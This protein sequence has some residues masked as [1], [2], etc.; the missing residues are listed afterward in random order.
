M[1]DKIKQTSLLL[2]GLILS[3]PLSV[4]ADTGPWYQ[5]EVLVF[6][7]IAPGAGSTESWKADPGTP[8]QVGAAYLSRGPALVNN[9]PV[10]YRTLP[11]EKRVLN[12]AWGVMRRSRDYRPLYHVAWRQQVKSP[13]QAKPIYFSLKPK[14]G[15]PVSDTNPPL[16]EG[17]IKFG[18]KRY[19]HLETDII[20][21]KTINDS[22]PD[23]SDGYRYGPTIRSYRM[24]DSRRMRSGKLHYLDHPVL[25]VLAIAKRY[26]MPAP[27]VE[28]P[29][30]P[31]EPSLTPANEPQTTPGG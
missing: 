11:A 23:D 5:F 1:I 19:L 12:G 21:R 8:S 27:V 17:T 7:R 20:L 4:S 13:N 2:L 30:Q 9:K 24:Q 18:I 29:L 3:C 6:Q 28:K 25:G 31:E 16:L 15:A 22:Q 14:N 26:K 10:A